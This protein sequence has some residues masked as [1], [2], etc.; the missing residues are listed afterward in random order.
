MG[1]SDEDFKFKI[2]RKIALLKEGKWNKELNFV[3]W[4]EGPPKYD[5]RDWSP[6][7]KKMGKGVALNEGE[8]TILFNALRNE[9]KPKT[10]ATPSTEEPSLF[11]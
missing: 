4:N 1:D 10:P 9:F 8:A 2:V 7:H 11:K 5:I 3:S 6:D